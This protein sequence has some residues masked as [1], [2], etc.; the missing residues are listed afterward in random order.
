M[1]RCGDGCELEYPALARLCGLYLHADW[2]E[3]YHDDWEALEAFLDL[4]PGLAAR[5]PAEVEHVLARIQLEGKL[6]ELLVTHLGCAFWPYARSVTYRQW[7][8]GM[9]D[10]VRDRLT[11]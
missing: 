10:Q 7:L 3:E 4:E 5:L 11:A 9:A 8:E 6:V 2:P 1:M